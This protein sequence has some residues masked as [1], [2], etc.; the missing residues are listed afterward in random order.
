MNMT[1]ENQQKQFYE[2]SDLGLV[3]TLS[4]YFP[5]TTMDRSNPKKIIFI[6]KKEQK[7]KELI[8]AYWCR[9]LQVEPQAYFSQLRAIKARLYEGH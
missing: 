1:I 9:E 6:F 2:C 3:T 8:E 4:L 7:L 5:I